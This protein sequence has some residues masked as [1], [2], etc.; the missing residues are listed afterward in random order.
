MLL[1]THHSPLPMLLLLCCTFR[2]PNPVSVRP[3]PLGRAG[4]WPQ[5]DSPPAETE[6]AALV[7]AEAMARTQQA[8]Q[9]SLGEPD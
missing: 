5:P 1:I 8:T 6:P 7:C 4:A 2:N 9:G 3:G